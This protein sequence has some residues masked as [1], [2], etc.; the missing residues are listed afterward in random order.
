M[1]QQHLRG[2]FNK[3]PY[4][5]VQAF[6][7]FVDSWQFNMLLLPILW[8]DWPN[9]MISGSNEQLQQEL[10]YTL[11]K[12]NCYSWWISKMKSGWV[13]T[14]EEQYAKNS[15]LNFEKRHK[16]VRNASDCFSIILHESRISFWVA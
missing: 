3:F 10:E 9:F 16:N 6:N 14:L 8:D 1:M 13:D 12:P 15:V 2:A 4:F 5:F 7:I 11:Q